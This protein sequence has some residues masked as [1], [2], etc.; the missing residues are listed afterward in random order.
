MRILVDEWLPLVHRHTLCRRDMA[1][2]PGRQIR[3]QPDTTIR[4]TPATTVALPAL[5]TDLVH[6]QR[7]RAALWVES[8]AE[9]F[10]AR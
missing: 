1:D 7:R 10:R 3:C 4:D 9:P 2:S 8:H 5:D 6:V